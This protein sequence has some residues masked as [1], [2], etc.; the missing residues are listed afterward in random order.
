MLKLHG[1]EVRNVIFEFSKFSHLFKEGTAVLVIRARD[2]VL[3]MY[4]QYSCFHHRACG[5][6]KVNFR[7]SSDRMKNLKT[8]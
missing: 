3:C 2:T 6:T 7:T 4:V 1:V 8:A 5:N